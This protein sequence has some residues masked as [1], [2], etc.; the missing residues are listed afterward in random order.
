MPRIMLILHI[1]NLNQKNDLICI[2]D[3]RLSVYIEYNRQHI[4]D[5]KI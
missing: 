5:G 2:Y 3:H 4:G 1:Q